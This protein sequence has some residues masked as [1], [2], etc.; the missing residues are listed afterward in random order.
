MH[1]EWASV[2]P[3]PAFSP[4]AIVAVQDSTGALSWPPLGCSQS[5]ASGRASGTALF[6]PVVCR[7]T[8][9]AS[10]IASA[11]PSFSLVAMHLD[12]ISHLA[13]VAATPARTAGGAALSA[14]VVRGPPYND[15]GIGPDVR[16]R[17]NFS[18]SS[19][20]EGVMLD[21]K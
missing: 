17:R 15:S 18:T 3:L 16:H 6:S 14:P 10:A 8:T 11:P 4:H 19:Q 1:K 5:D 13:P 9:V 2:T 21:T 12:P 20:R 7:T